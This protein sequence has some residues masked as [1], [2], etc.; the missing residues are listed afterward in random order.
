MPRD[1]A[2]QNIRDIED[3]P[4]GLFCGL[5]GWTDADGGGSLTVGIRSGIVEGCETTLFAGAG[6]VEG[7]RA[8]Q[9]EQETM[10]K[11]SALADLL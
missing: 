3:G 10:L 6:I 11:M 7:S 4:R 9:E 5:V 1:K 2:M 8:E